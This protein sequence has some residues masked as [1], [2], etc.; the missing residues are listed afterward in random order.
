[1]I[2]WKCLTHFCEQGAQIHL[3]PIFLNLFLRLLRSLFIRMTICASLSGTFLVYVI[4]FVTA[5]L[6]LASHFTIKIVP[7]W[8]IGYMKSFL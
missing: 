4:P 1:M 7:I 8:E 3:E 6:F 5:Q 2:I